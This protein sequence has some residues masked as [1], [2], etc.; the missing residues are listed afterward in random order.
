M[1]NKCIVFGRNYND[2][3]CRVSLILELSRN[4]SYDVE[5]ITIPTRA[6]T[7]LSVRHSISNLNEISFQ[8]VFEILC[9]EHTYILILWLFRNFEL[10][11]SKIIK[12]RLWPLVWTKVLNAIF[13]R[14]FE[15]KLLHY[16]QNKLI[17]I[18]DIYLE[19]KRSPIVDFLHRHQELSVYCLSHGQQTL[20][21]LW[22]DVASINQRERYDARNI[23]VYVPS[24]IDIGDLNRK[25]KNFNP[26]VI[27]NTRFDQYWIDNYPLRSKVNKFHSNLDH[28]RKILF[29]MSK[30][31]YGQDANEVRELILQIVS[32]NR[33]IL[34]LKPHTRGMKLD[35]L[36]LPNLENLVVEEHCETTD[37]ITWADVVL[38]TGSSIIFEAFIRKKP[39]VFLKRLQKYASIFD[40]LPQLNIYDG[41]DDICQVIQNAMERLDIAFNRD[42]YLNEHVF[43]NTGGNV[44]S[45]FIKKYLI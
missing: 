13:N 24:K 44:C 9:N 7:G 27:G 28:R 3:D 32:N 20:I 15:R 4:N 17:I 25:A 23:D 1:K 22:Y 38:F 35:E 29:T 40:D 8:N 45:S 18:D 2:I 31:N 19:P 10:N 41:S 16:L 21:N 43:G 12:F 26:I 42:E 36:N 30:L 6:S 37:L 11:K 34:C 39:V 5:V 33:V 14:R